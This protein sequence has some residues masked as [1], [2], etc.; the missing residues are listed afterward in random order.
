MTAKPLLSVCIP[1]RNE[2]QNITRSID[3]IHGELGAAGV[4]H[5]LDRK[6]VV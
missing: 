2:E 1:A 4:P 5:E 3:T 6:S